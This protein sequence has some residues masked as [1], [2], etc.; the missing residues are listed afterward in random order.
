VRGVAGSLQTMSPPMREVLTTTANATAWMGGLIRRS[1]RLSGVG[2]SRFGRRRA[3]MECS[4][5]A[6]CKKGVLWARVFWIDWSLCPNLRQ[7]TI[8]SWQHW[9]QQSKSRSM[10]VK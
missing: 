1:S 7:P 2:L 3:T 5:I 10:R 9:W 4:S 6:R 8:I